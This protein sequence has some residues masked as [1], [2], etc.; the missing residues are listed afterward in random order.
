[1][2]VTATLFGVE[3]IGQRREFTEADCGI[4]R[5]LDLISSGDGALASVRSGLQELERS[6]VWLKADSTS[7]DAVLPS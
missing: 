3:L 6:K 4:A 2:P 5:C 1:M 7:L